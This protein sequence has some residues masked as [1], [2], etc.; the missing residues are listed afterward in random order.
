[1]STTAST[2]S[3]F[4]ISASLEPFSL[5]TAIGSTR[6]AFQFQFCSTEIVFRVAGT[7][8]KKAPLS[9]SDISQFKDFVRF[10]GL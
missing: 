4:E 8:N 3:A 6:T 5:Y 10:V 2:F 9:P 7:W 1:V